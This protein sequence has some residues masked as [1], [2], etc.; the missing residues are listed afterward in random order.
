MIVTNKPKDN[1]D[2]RE[3]AGVHLGQAPYNNPKLFIGRESDIM[4]MEAI[5]SPDAKSQE[6]RRLVLGGK[7]GI[8]KTQL[9]IAYANRYRH[10]Y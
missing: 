3:P 2:F 1:F 5:L 8:G 7:G 10:H 6:H 4:K 9:A